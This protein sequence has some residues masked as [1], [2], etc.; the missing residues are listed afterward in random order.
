MY[1]CMYVCNALYS[2]ISTNISDLAVAGAGC[3]LCGH[4]GQELVE[5]HRSVSVRVHAVEEVDELLRVLEDGVLGSVVGCHIAD[6]FSKL[7]QV[8]ATGAIHIQAFT[9][10][11]ISLTR[12]LHSERKL[13]LNIERNW[14]ARDGRM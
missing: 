7:F 6:S 12:H 8:D 1:V 4:S 11:D 3:A 2:I 13:P 9:T 14:S 5:V 10:Y